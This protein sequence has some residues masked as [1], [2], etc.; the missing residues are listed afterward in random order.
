MAASINSL[1]SNALRQISSVETFWLKRVFP[2]IWFGFCGF[3]FLINVVIGFAMAKGIIGPDGWP[4]LA[5]PIFA[6]IFGYFYFHYA[7]SDLADAVFDG[8]DSLVF[9]REDKEVRIPLDE[10]M[11]VVFPVFGKPL[12][13]ELILRSDT[14]LGRKVAFLPKRPIKF[15]PFA[16]NPIVDDLIERMNKTRRPE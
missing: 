13:V 2:V 14:L 16:S 10:I 8:G 6:L 9:H 1:H 7:V 5:V 12:R 3:I 11:S 15:N 4:V